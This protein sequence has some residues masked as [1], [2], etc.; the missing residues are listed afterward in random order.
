MKTTP[1]TAMM[2]A[3]CTTASADELL[4]WTLDDAGGAAVRE[5]ATGARDVAVAIGDVGRRAAPLAPDGGYAMR[6]VSDDPSSFVDAPGLY[7]LRCSSV[8]RRRTRAR[9]CPWSRS[10]GA[11]RAR[12]SS[13]RGSRA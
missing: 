9:A 6:F 3:L 12:S 1:I 13:P 10:P 2:L 11:S 5:A 7:L 8:R 4:H